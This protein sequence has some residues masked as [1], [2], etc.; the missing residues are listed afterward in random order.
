MILCMIHTQKQPNRV[1]NRPLKDYSG[2]RF[3]FL[4]AKRLVE[5]D[6]SK[7][8]NHVWLFDCDCGNEKA[9]KIKSVRSGSTSSC[10]CKFSKMMADRNTSHGLAGKSLAYRS[11]KD[12][13]QRC[14]N[15]NNVDWLSYGGRGIKVCEKWDDFLAFLSDMGERPDN[16]SI[17]RIDVNLGYSK[18]NCRWA[19]DKVQANNKRSNYRIE[20]NG[21]SATLQE[22]ADKVGIKRETISARIRAGWP[23]DKVFNRVAKPPR[24]VPE[25][26][27]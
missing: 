15:P 20:Y 25:L 19:L 9:A 4:V 2:K 12:M 13:R 18:E 5:R 22:W 1:R 27:E 17:D 8:N 26:A 10:G 14:N 7:E 21:C 6:A 16:H 3:G 11:W 24:F 23:L